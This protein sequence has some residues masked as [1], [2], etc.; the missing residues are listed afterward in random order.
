LA[1]AAGFAAEIDRIVRDPKMRG[2][3]SRRGHALVDG[4]GASRVLDALKGH[5]ALDA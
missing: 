2:V 4:K 5:G 1:D 3:L